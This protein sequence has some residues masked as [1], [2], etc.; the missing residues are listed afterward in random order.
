VRFLILSLLLFPQQT[1]PAQPASASAASPLAETLQQKLDGFRSAGKFPGATVGVAFEK[2]ESIALATGVAD[3][4]SGRA[5]AATDRLAAGSAGKLCFA[6]ALLKRVQSGEIALDGKVASYFSGDP[7][8]R[9]LPNAEEMTVR[10]LLNHSSGLV[11][12]ELDGRFLEDLRKNPLRS[13]TVEQRL[14]YLFDRK[15]PFAAGQGWDYSDT[16]YIVLGAILERVARRAAYEEIE[17]N[18]LKPNGLTGF[19]RFDSPVTP[20]LVPG[21]AGTSDPILGEDKTLRDGKFVINPQFEWAGGGF[22]CTAVDLARLGRLYFEGQLFGSA[23]LPQV[24]DGIP[25]P[26]LGRSTKYGLCAILWQTPLGEA[27]GH[28]GY[29]PGY[30]TEVRYFPEHRFAVAMQINT[31]DAKALPKPL[32]AM[33]VELAKAV[34]ASK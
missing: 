4:E 32:G 3:R 18:V 9:R 8:F 2:G 25:A 26:M 33:I 7:W 16:N 15:A 34:S 20:A 22:A 29:F 13:W 5:M 31:S 14:E 21:Y 27:R 24:V 12:Y 1:R 23:L 11:R 10:Q 30:L 6:A 19:V 17:E 28:S